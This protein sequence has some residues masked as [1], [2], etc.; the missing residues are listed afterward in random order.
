MQGRLSR[1]IARLCLRRR[2]ELQALGDIAA[3]GEVRLS[4][5]RWKRDFDAGLTRRLRGAEARSLYDRR[6]L[7]R[8]LR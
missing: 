1:A 2:V 3:P 8:A 6:R 4:L 7:N 5:D